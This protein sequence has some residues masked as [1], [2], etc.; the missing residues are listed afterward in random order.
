MPK[1][2]ST[3]GHLPLSSHGL[4]ILP[5]LE[6]HLC[7]RPQCMRQPHLLPDRSSHT[8]LCQ[9]LTLP[10]A[11]GLALPQVPG[12]VTPGFVGIS[13]ED[14]SGRDTESRP[15]PWRGA[16]TT[17]QRLAVGHCVCRGPSAI[18]QAQ[19]VTSSWVLGTCVLI[20]MWPL[21]R[22]A[23]CCQ[24]PLKRWIVCDLLLGSHLC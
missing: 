22:K 9:P 16:A 21:K 6:P 18:A 24:S 2:M 4:R 5:R 3:L 10:T 15:R 17:H 14:S 13:M 8:G 1:A 7:S 20:N 11:Q 12:I 23:L 19:C